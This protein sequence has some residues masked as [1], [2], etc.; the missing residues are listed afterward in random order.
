MNY[1]DLVN[2]TIREAG[3]ED[4]YLTSLNFANAEAL[5]PMYGKVKRWVN[6]AWNGIQLERDDYRW[7]TG[8]GMVLLRPR[9]R[10]YD[11]A[12]LG[13]GTFSGNAIT[14][15]TGIEFALS[16]PIYTDT[17]ETEG[18]ADVIGQPTTNDGLGDDNALY[19]NLRQGENIYFPDT[20]TPHSTYR[21]FGW[22]EYNFLDQNEPLD[23]NLSDIAEI[24]Q[25][26]LRVISDFSD[27][28]QGTPLVYLPYNEWQLKLP[29]V[30]DAPGT[31]TSYT[32]NIQGKFIFNPPLDRP[33]R[34]KFNYTRKPQVLVAYNDIPQGLK[35]ELHEIIVWKALRKYGEYDQRPGVQARADREIKAVMRRQERHDLPVPHFD[36]GVNW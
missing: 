17:A 21:F 27:N 9:L 1:L 25:T 11:A 29:W 19:A 34:V 2:E 26:T 22:G 33:Y 12:D 36:P 3:I 24:H 7:Q 35:A 30:S 18:Y 16:P 28:A 20:D 6:Q 23:T 13:A 8:S 14:G 15:E 10:F 32:Q 4:E 31:P 5:A